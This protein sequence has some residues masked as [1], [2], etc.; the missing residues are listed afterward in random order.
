M[1][2]SIRDSSRLC[3]QSAANPLPGQKVGA[4]SCEFIPARDLSSAPTPAVRRNLQTPLTARNIIAIKTAL[5]QLS[6]KRYCVL[7]MGASPIEN[8]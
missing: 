1:F 7:V 5:W 4:S 6:Q 3:A 8:L 2:A